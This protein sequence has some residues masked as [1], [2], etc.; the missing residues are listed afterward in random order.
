[1]QKL[2]DKLF[3][4]VKTLQGE[5]LCTQIIVFVKDFEKTLSALKEKNYRIK[6]AF[7]FINAICIEISLDG[8][9]GLTRLNNVIY[10]AAQTNVSAQSAIAKAITNVN[11][12]YKENIF[13]KG[14]TVAVI[15]TGIRP[16]LD[17][18]YP[19][20]RIV[21][22]VDLIN[23]EGRNK[24][25]VANKV[26]LS[27]VSCAGTPLKRR[28]V[29]VRGQNTTDVLAP[30]DDN[31]HGT[32][33][34]GLVGGNGTMS[35]H[36]YSGFAPLCNLIAIKAL[37]KTGQ[38]TSVEML[39]SMQWVYDNKEKYNIGVV[40]MSFGAIPTSKSDPLMKGAEQLWDSGIVVVAAG[41][42][43]GPDKQTIKSPGASRKIITV[44]SLDDARDE[45][46]NFYKDKFKIAD[47]SSRGPAFEFYK[48]DLVVSGVNLVSCGLTSD[49]SQMSG[50]SVSAPIVAGICA[51]IL[52][53]YKQQITPNQI[54][55]MLRNYCI[56]IAKDRNAEGFGY[57]D[58]LKNG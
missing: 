36:K 8:L 3:R 14:V 47:F 35:G 24:P 4:M 42:N 9:V 26:V 27:R 50:T 19:Q 49:Y 29:L 46:E 6:A 17:F 43:S 39:E 54:K 34:A 55:N 30:Y 32:F 56:P 13:G 18:L 2:D 53:K 45:H 51:L 15:D 1:M 25:T 10:V 28:A 57:L 41:G 20:S 11:E 38:S 16:H 12:F 7:P 5:P 37:D 33:V 31:G 22:F 52:E 23:K 21:K 48:P 44:G 40:C 58:F